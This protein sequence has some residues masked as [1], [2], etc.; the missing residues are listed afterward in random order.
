MEHNTPVWKYYTREPDGTPFVDPLYRP[1]QRRRVRIRPD[2]GTS[3]G[4]DAPPELRCAEKGCEIDITSHA[5]QD[6]PLESVY[7][8]LERKGWGLSFQRQFSYDPCPHGWVGG[9]D[10][11]CFQDL[12]EY[13][14]IFYTKDAFVPLNQYWGSYAPSLDQ[15]DPD[16]AHLDTQGRPWRSNYGLTDNDSQYGRPGGTYSYLIG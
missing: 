15:R 16:A 3:C 1:Y 14:P 6:Q 10:G 13:D 7:P 11:W 2:L 4:K 12:P 9:E 8:A 5:L